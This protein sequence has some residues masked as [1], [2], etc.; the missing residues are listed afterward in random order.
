MAGKLR[1]GP[2]SIDHPHLGVRVAAGVV[3]VPTLDEIPERF[4]GRIDVMP[5]DIERAQSARAQFGGAG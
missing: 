2:V 3:R 5:L 4:A 1:S